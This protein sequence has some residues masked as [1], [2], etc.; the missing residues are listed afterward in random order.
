MKPFDKYELYEKSVQTPDS[1]V[2][3]LNKWYTRFHGRKPLSLREDFC[4]T[5]LLCYQ[6]VRQSERHTAVGLDLS[7]EPVLW[8]IK[9]HALKL[10]ASQQKRAQFFRK[11]VLNPP[12]KKSDIVVALNFS[13]LVFHEREVMRLYFERVRKT[14]NKKGVFFFDLMGGPE[15]QEITC[16]TRSYRG[17][18]YYWDCQSFDAIQNTGRYFI[19]FKRKGEKMRKAV[20][21]YYWRLYNLRELVDIAKDAGFRKVVTFWEKET[22]T[23]A[24]TG[25]Y[26]PASKAK[27]CAAWV[28][29][30]AAIP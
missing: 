17:F 8:G 19:H 18:K 11:N 21:E 25:I 13:Y 2:E 5:G 15:C 6:W 14:L 26:Y 20:F 4:G 22:R 12:A 9:K 1:D 10:T 7:P 29:T 27:N 30:V 23:G 24:G 3:F 16:D 28:V